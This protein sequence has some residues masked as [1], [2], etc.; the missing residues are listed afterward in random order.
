MQKQIISCG[1]ILFCDGRV[2]LGH[3]TK[4]NRSINKNDLSWGIPKGR[5]ELNEVESQTAIREFREETGCDLTTVGP[6]TP[7]S[8]YNTI[9]KKV[10]VFLC[11]DRNQVTKNFKFFCD[12]YIEDR[13]E[14]DSFYWAT[15][16][17]ALRMVFNSQKPIFKKM[18]DEHTAFILPRQ[19]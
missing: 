6:I 11:D 12:S 17:E 1:V 8:T 2:L 14:L 13:P 9:N 3:A 7:F 5:M 19:N 16:L 4:P 18:L 10:I 15:P